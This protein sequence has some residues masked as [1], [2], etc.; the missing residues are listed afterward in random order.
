MNQKNLSPGNLFKAHDR[1]YM[2]LD[3]KSFA[4]GNE[5]GDINRKSY[6]EV[7]G[8]D[9]GGIYMDTHDEVALLDAFM[10]E[11]EA[12]SLVTIPYGSFFLH[13]GLGEALIKVIIR[14]GK[15]MGPYSAYLCARAKDG[16]LVILPERETVVEVKVVMREVPE[17]E[18]LQR[19]A[20][21][22][23]EIEDLIRYNP[24]TPMGIGTGSVI[25]SGIQ[26]KDGTWGPYTIG[27][28]IYY[29]DSKND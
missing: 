20:D 6:V 29:E 21:R 13:E 25:Y 17:G 3:N 1:T 16:Q 12:V 19:E 18:R 27:N 9:S 4:L 28:A 10:E 14:A 11:K 2:M 26:S 15:Y 22:R 7:G 5:G 23:R 24:G 8:A